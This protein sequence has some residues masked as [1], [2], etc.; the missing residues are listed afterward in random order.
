M[1]RAGGGGLA[2]TKIHTYGGN[3]P[4]TEG[5]RTMENPPKSQQKVID[6]ISRGAKLNRGRY[7]KQHADVINSHGTP[8]DIP[9]TVRPPVCWEMNTRILFLTPDRGADGNV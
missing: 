6:A 7:F 2:Y 5:P 1:R 8:R 3:N 4:K 9:L